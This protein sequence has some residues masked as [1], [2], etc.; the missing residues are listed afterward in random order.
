MVR[1]GLH[2]RLLTVTVDRHGAMMGY[3]E[4]PDREVAIDGLDPAE[5]AAVIGAVF[6]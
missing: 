2:R 4:K 6:D 1:E 3:S 5:V